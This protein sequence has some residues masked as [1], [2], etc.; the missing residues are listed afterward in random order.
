MYLEHYI[1]FYDLIFL[2]LNISFFIIFK[3]M[4]HLWKLGYAPEDMIGNIF[5]VAKNLDIKEE[6]KLE[7]VQ[8]NFLI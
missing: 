8:V 6:L 4:A 7:F 2:L 1:F 3:I 5:K